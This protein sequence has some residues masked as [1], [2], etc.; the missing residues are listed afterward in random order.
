M[1]SD[2]EKNWVRHQH[3]QRREDAL[4]TKSLP[5]MVMHITGATRRLRNPGRK[6]ACISRLAPRTPWRPCT[7]ARPQVASLRFVLISVRFVAGL[8][9]SLRL[10]YVKKSV[11]NPSTFAG[12]CTRPRGCEAKSSHALAR[13]NEAHTKRANTSS[14]GRARSRCAIFSKTEATVISFFQEANQTLEDQR[15][16]RRASI[17]IMYR[18]QYS[19]T[20]RERRYATTKSRIR[21]ATSALDK[22]VSGNTSISHPPHA[23]DHPK[24]F[25]KFER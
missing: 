3:H 13:H 5:F 14:T 24:L 11:S 16:T 19:C 10:Q 18:T 12:R 9:Q 22:I 15:E 20:T 4:V 1:A 6:E 23:G 7:V 17:R 2:S 25:P 21:W 8:R